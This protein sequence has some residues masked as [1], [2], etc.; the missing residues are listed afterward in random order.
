MKLTSG[1]MLWT[2]LDPVLNKY[3]YLSENITCDIAIIGGGISGSLCAYYLCQA[4]IDTVMVDKNIIGYG[5]TSASTSILQYEI[6]SDITG[7]KKSIGEE[8]AIKAFKLCEKSVYEIKDIVNSLGDDC[9]FL[10]NECFYYTDRESKIK[11]FE[12][13]FNIRKSNG[14]D[15]EFIDEHKAKE[16]FSFPVKAGIYSKSGSAQINPYK[17]THKLISKS[18]QRGLRV[19]ENTEVINIEN[20]SDGV[21]LLTRNGFEIKA[22]KVLIA[23]GYESVDFL[24]E[25]ISKFYRTFT[26]VTKPINRFNGWHNKCIIRDDKD[27]Y[28]Y[29]RTTSDNRIIIGGQDEKVGMINNFISNLSSDEKKYEKL[30]DK[31]KDMFPY[32]N[33]IEI[34]YKFNGLFGITD[35]GLPYIGVHKDFPNYYFSLNYGSNGILYATISGR[36]I[37]DLHLGKFNKDLD[38]FRFGR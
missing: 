23:A 38:L 24:N 15:V 36:L 8:N 25:N 13:E 37:T 28:T 14:F 22:S 26:L 6:D 9:G 2:N 18:V 19:Y 17:F 21:V 32:I 1:D 5:S 7:L 27:P 12:D 35:D 33:D 10:I 29:L 16:M 20:I 30:F 11:D 4:G 31:L 34:E 3:D